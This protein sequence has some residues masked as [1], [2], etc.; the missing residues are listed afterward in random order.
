MTLF[1]R[2]IFLLFACFLSFNTYL[3]DKNFRAILLDAYD[4][5]LDGAKILN[6]SNKN[7]AFSDKRGSFIISAKTLDSLEIKP[8]NKPVFFY[9]VQEIGE[10]KSDIVFINA[11][12]PEVTIFDEVQVTS[13]RVKKVITRKNAN[14]I[15]YKLCKNGRVLSLTSLRNKF[16]LNIEAHD[17]VI[18][19]YKLKGGR[20]SEVFNDLFG[21]TFLLK[22]D[23]SFQVALS[24]E[25]ITVTSNS[26]EEFDNLIR[27]IVY[28]NDSCIVS[29][30]SCFS[31]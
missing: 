19:K 6:L 4:N 20:Y 25:L 28:T 18:K 23:S 2:V 16:W 10:G 5:P 22:K 27:P 9:Q 31:G 7:V 15:D 3:Q 1:F 21:N 13:S 17:D 30:H 8:Q 14:V 12:E 29:K 11:D 26:L 24:D